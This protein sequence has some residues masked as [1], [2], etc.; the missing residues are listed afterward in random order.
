MRGRIW[1]VLAP[2]VIA[3]LALLALG[4]MTGNGG[5]QATGEPVDQYPPCKVASDQ[6]P[7]II[8]DRPYTAEYKITLV[9]ISSGGTTGTPESTFVQARDSQGRT[10][11]S[12]QR[13][14]SH[15]MAV[16]VE[17]EANGIRTSWDSRSKKATVI[18]EPPPE[19]RYG[20]WSTDSGDGGV[21]Y[22]CWKGAQPSGAG[23][24]IGDNGS[25]AVP[26]VTAP[27]PKQTGIMETREDIGAA[28]IQGI[29]AHGYRTT[30]TIAIGQTSKDQ[31]RVQISEEWV[32][33]D[34][35]IDVRTK[36][37]FLRGDHQTGETTVELVKLKQSEPDPALFEPPAGYKVLTEGMHEVPCEEVMP[38][39][40]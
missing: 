1:G 22:S 36:T 17:D 11:T 18:K 29:K 5:G 9:R 21:E 14:H 20:C 40:H 34:L 25:S 35:E 15:T 37:R 39:A 4:Q 32:A 13:A 19:K 31:P 12:G 38:S 7:T 33:T 2:V 26:A 16:N 30:T 10:M 27:A 24:L 3:G 23:A 6:T 8:K 28:T